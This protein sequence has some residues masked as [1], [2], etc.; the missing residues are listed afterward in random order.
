MEN[1]SS[2]EKQL[3]ELD[4]AWK[5]FGISVKDCA[6]GIISS[7]SNLEKRLKKEEYGNNPIKI[8][9]VKNDKRRIN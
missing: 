2:F 8:R 4:K 6:D 3:E 1:M 5:E 7:F 9:G